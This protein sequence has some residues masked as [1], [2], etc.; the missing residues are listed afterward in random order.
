MT[1]PVLCQILGEEVVIDGDGVC[2]TCGAPGGLVCRLAPLSPSLL[3]RIR[4]L[5]GDDAGHEQAP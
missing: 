1:D 5:I 2:L 4:D 3:Q